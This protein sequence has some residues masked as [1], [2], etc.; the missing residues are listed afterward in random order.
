MSA[1]P[2]G[3]PGIDPLEPVG[4]SPSLQEALSK[5]E[6]EGHKRAEV[7]NQELAMREVCVCVCASVCMCMCVHVCVYVE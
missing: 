1:P 7:L 6:E 3:S 4:V 5:L 2:T